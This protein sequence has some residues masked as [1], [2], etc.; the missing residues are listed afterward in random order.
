MSS[1]HSCLCTFRNCSGERHVSARANSSR[2]FEQRSTHE[3]SFHGSEDEIHHF[4][5]SEPEVVAYP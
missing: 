2:F 5:F 4:I 3:A 1:L